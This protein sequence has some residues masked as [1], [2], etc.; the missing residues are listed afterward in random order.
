MRD[1]TIALIGQA[2]LFTTAFDSGETFAD[3]YG[4][5]VNLKYWLEDSPITED[6]VIDVGNFTIGDGVEFENEASWGPLTTRIDFTHDSI[7][8]SW[9]IDNTNSNGNY[10]VYSIPAMFNNKQFTFLGDSPKISGASMINLSSSVG[11][12]GDYDLWEDVDPKIEALVDLLYL[13]PNSPDRVYIDNDSTI[14]FNSQGFYVETGPFSTMTV[15]GEIHID[16]E[17][18]SDIDDNGSVN[19]DDLLALVATWGDCPKGCSAD[20]NEDLV[21]NIDDLLLLIAAWGD[22]P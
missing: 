11:W 1:L 18:E 12:V 7:I 6:V 17:C 19:V 15:T 5:E 2:A 21:V 4:H 14:Q 22:C 13:D 9:T 8:W 3:L 20:V 16:F 10:W